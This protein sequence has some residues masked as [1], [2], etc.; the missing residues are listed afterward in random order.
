MLRGKSA[1]GAAVLEMCN[2]LVSFILLA[3][4]AKSGED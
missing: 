3:M 1:S 4:R 2:E